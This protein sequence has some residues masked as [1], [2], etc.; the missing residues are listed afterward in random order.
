[1]KED[2]M[3]YKFAAAVLSIMLVSVAV[4]PADDGFIDI[5]AGLAFT[6]Y[7]DVRIP[8]ESGTMVSLKTDTVPDP[9]FAL[10]VRIGYAFGERHTVF[11]LAAPLLVRGSGITDRELIY[12]GATF[13]AGT[14][15]ESTYRFDSY[16]LSYRYLFI[17]GN[18]FSLAAGLTAKLRSAD[19]SLMSDTA[20]ARRSDLGVVPLISFMAEWKLVP[21]LSLLIDGDALVTPFGRAEDVLAALQYRPSDSVAYRLGYRILEGGSEAGGSVYTFA[22]F[23]Y[24]TMGLTVRF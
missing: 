22:L 8:S 4:L 2:Y 13:P 6:G 12:F 1:M 17:D 10:R 20:Y 18:S 9:A 11:A 24:V 14:E 16:R 15:L 23:H 21:Q 7:N 5:E 3:K 19:I